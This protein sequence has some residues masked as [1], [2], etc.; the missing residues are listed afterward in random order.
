VSENPT[1][2]IVDDN[3][4]GREVLG[5]V[6]SGRGYAL[7]FASNGLEALSQA[8]EHTPDLVLLDVMMPG[9]DGFEVC[10]RLRLD[11]VTAEVPVLLITS[12]D[13]SR[14][15]EEGLAAGADDFIS[16]PFD[17][18]EM[19]ARVK[20]IV[21]LNRYRRILEER[22][23]VNQLVSFSPD[24]ITVVDANGQIKLAN[25]AFSN[26]LGIEE[27]DLKCM[28]L[29][30]L[31]DP[32]HLDECA[33]RF[34]ILM[35][36]QALSQLVEIEMIRASGAR[37][38][39][40]VSAAYCLW[41][42]EPSV[43]MVIRN[44]TN[45]KSLEAQLRQ[46]QKLEAIGQLTSGIAHDFNNILSVVMLSA[47]LIGGSLSSDDE[48]LCADVVHIMTAA[49]SGA[50]MIK[51]LM[52]MSRKADLR[53]EP[54]D[55]GP[56]VVGL[57][58][59]LRRLLPENIELKLAVEK[60]TPFVQA[61]TGAVEQMLMNLATNA[62]D[63]MPDG[64]TFRVEVSEVTLDVKNEMEAG[65]NRSVKCLCITASD[66]GMGMAAEIKTRV[67]EPFFTTKSRGKGTGLGMAMIA[68]LIK[69]HNGFVEVQSEV[70]VGT[71]I[72]LSFPT[73]GKTERETA[74]SRSSVAVL[75]GSGTILIAEDEESLRW[76]AERVLKR[77]GYTVL[78][79]ADGEEALAVFRAHKES[80]ELVISDVGMPK[81][82]GVELYREIRRESAEV[83]FLFSSGRVRGEITGASSGLEQVP[84]LSKPWT[85]AELVERVREALS[86][87]GCPN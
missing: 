46:S 62:R 66:N 5:A 13:G 2:L 18:H 52:G 76:A 43:Q 85:L 36:N 40:E 27:A 65:E 69:Q 24:G 51:K 20:T 79:A 11:S 39:V 38:S 86:E 15:R 17:R 55:L 16:K 33:V 80:I 23:K 82:D 70:G 21:R 12:L 1:I 4:M 78:L 57:Y 47:E 25:P 22:A 60:D 6:L 10:R 87:E 3:A 68:G 48:E 31:I 29:W 61:D 84:C 58:S 50:R 34:G 59:I 73:V 63:A 7:L 75:E 74:D 53:L 41:D 8:R 49:H 37:V 45:R 77:F 19:R 32:K 28:S 35:E 83:K 72:R 54:T 44:I 9:M 64:G 67:F 56:V 81:M 42:Q 26:M 71:T 14:S 30:S